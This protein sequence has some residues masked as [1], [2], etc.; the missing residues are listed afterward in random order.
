[1]KVVL[2][3]SV[4][5]AIYERI[6]DAKRCNRKVDYILVTRQEYD[7]VRCE[8]V[9]NWAL[10]AAAIP[11]DVTVRTVELEHPYKKYDSYR[12]ASYET[13]YGFPLYVVPPEYISN[14]E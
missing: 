4:L 9:P 3:P 11:R 10:S 13:L 8:A 14:K 12:F 2:K 6:S 5:D 1:M 7:E